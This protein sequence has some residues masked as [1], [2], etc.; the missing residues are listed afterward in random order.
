MSRSPLGRK[1]EILEASG[2]TRP[3]TGG[4]GDLFVWTI[5][6]ILLVGLAIGAWMGSFHIFGHPE[7][8]AS[9]TILTK[10]DKLDPPARF[11]LTDAPRGEFLKPETLIERYEKMTPRQLARENQ[12]LQRNF[13]R[14]YKVVSGLVPYVVG[15]FTILDSYELAETDYFSPGVV[16]L[17]Q[18]KTEPNCLIEHIF[19]ADA[20][21][22]PMLHRM[23]LT[24]LDLEL[25]RRLDLSALINVRRLEDG[26]MQFTAVPLTYGSYA[27]TAGPGTLTLDPPENV[28]VAAG[29]PVIGEKRTKDATAK[30]AN[31][32]RRAGLGEPTE[33]SGSEGA[34]HAQLIRVERPMPVAGKAPPPPPVPEATP[35]PPPATLLMAEFASLQQE[36]NQTPPTPTPTAAPPTPTPAPI[37]STADGSWPLYDPGRMP[38][39]RLLNI[40]D[41]P[42]LA[43]RGLAGE[44]IY[45]QGNFVVT[46]SGP[47]R[48]V[49]R[50]QT[51]LPESLGLRGR[52]SK[53][54]I[55]AEFPA[56]TK[57]PS[58]G[59][60]FARDSVRPF[61]ITEVRAGADG[62]INV[63]V[64]EVT[65]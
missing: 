6:I 23:L 60:T 46:A 51:S 12:E 21:A 42:D 40:K 18:A 41:M 55:I 17:A 44:R 1:K 25:K 43:E 16:V 34:A 13:I 31:Y 15:D 3:K 7:T 35:T 8:P 4:G 9:H 5:A 56:A 59:S 62:Q 11:E 65:R 47:N 64:R 49:L 28:R 39:G 36:P 57:P 48:A 14:N 63:F 26:R 54:R 29:L 37:T 38:R 20:K 22:V 33:S 58:E 53:V 45:L 19:T 10:L 24:G 30:Y 50:S 61:Q 27:T 2:H 52:T 32:R